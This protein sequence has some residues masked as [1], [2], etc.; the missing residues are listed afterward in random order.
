MRVICLT[1][2][3]GSG[4]SRVAALLRQLGAAVIS[5][6]EV[7]RELSRPGTDVHRAIVAAFGPD[8]VA[9]DGTLDRRALGRRVFADPEA[10]RCLEGIT[11]PAIRKEM[12]Q[13][14]AALRAAPDPPPAVVLEIPLLF[15]TGGRYP[16]D[17]VWVVYAPEEVRVA[18]VM[19]RDGLSRDEVLAR[20]RAQWPLEE[21][22]RRADVVIDNGGPWEDAERQV[23]TAWARLTRAAGLDAPGRPTVDGG[24]G[25]DDGG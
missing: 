13:R 14:L 15:E 21:K 8:V 9:A 17:Q 1:G 22:V 2:G 5:A 6:D 18:R 4:K 25:G 12:E 19:A 16:C 10:R 20:M 7:A 11:H 23:R 24:A 3:I